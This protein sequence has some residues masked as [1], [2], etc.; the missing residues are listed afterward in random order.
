MCKLTTERKKKTKKRQKMPKI[1]RKH[2]YLT[3]RKDKYTPKIRKTRR[4][5]IHAEFCKCIHL[6]AISIE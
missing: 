4:I 3:D 1:A 5:H 2:A 6:S